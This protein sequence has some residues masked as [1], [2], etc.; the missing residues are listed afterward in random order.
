MRADDVYAILKGK[1]VKLTEDIKSMGNWKPIQHKG[2]VQT[3]DDLPTDA[4]EGWMY[5]IATDSIYGAAGM[6]VVM[7]SEGWDPMG[8]IINM[9]PYLTK[10]EGN[11]TFQPKG[12][13]LSGTDSD[14]KESGKA[15]DAKA[16]GEKIAKNSFDITKKLDKNQGV[17]NSGKIAGINESGDIVPIFPVGVDY[18]SETNCLE[19]GSDQKMKLNQGIGLDNTLTKSGSAADAGVTG[20]K[21]NSLKEDIGEL[22]NNYDIVK[23]KNIF[24]YKSSVYA[25]TIDNS[26]SSTVRLNSSRANYI[27][28]IVSVDGGEKYTLKADPIRR[29]LAFFSEMPKMD[30]NNEVGYIHPLFTIDGT[31]TITAPTNAKYA[32]VCVDCDSNLK[33]TRDVYN[34]MIY[35]GDEYPS[36]YVPYFEPYKVIDSSVKLQSQNINGYDILNAIKEE[37]GTNVF[38][39]N[40]TKIES[41][42]FQGKYLA[43]ASNYDTQIVEVEPNQK[44]VLDDVFIGAVTFFNETFDINQTFL[45]GSSYYG[46]VGEAAIPL[47]KVVESPDG[48]KYMT[49]YYPKKKSTDNA[50]ICKGEVMPKVYIPYIR[51][52]FLNENIIVRKESIYNESPDSTVGNSIPNVIIDTDFSADSDDVVALRLAQWGHKEEIINLRAVI[53]DAISQYSGSALNAMMIDGGTPNV[54]IG[55]YKGENSVQAGTTYSK[56]ISENFTHTLNSNDDCEDGVKLYRKILASSKEK[57]TICCIG[58]QTVLAELLKSSADGYSSMSGSELVANKCERLI[59]M[60]CQ[61]PSGHEYNVYTDAASSK[62]VAENWTT[63]IVYCGFEVGNTVRTAKNMIVIDPSKTDLLTRSIDCDNSIFLQNGKASYDAMTVYTLLFGYDNG[64]FST[65]RGNV[66]IDANGNNTFTESDNGNHL[67][68]VKTMSDSIYANSIDE[69]IFLI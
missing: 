4:K 42:R 25:G 3:A 63:E 29:T 62:Y 55:V 34:C 54:K 15:A 14:L 19:F 2:T 28:Y 22:E 33:P 10:E 48:A 5:N 69:K 16:T 9:G 26:S 53:A 43:T 6:N 59:A 44:Y 60:G 65:V 46:E 39:N 49:V 1:L 23:S 27:T 30:G 50:M 24:N 7:T 47:N 68:L 51:S 13:Y 38:L 40:K 67:Y 56:M 58:V 20:K 64:V 57:V 17:E 66:A 21:I 8:P 18:N 31:M 36:V 41:A 45:I 52:N 11:K 35:Q 37:T 32:T 12:N 61:F